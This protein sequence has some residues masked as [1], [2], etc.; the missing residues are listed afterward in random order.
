MAKHTITTTRKTAIEKSK[1]EIELIG[2]TLLI[3]IRKQRD[4]S[5]IRTININSEYE[6]LQTTQKNRKYPNKMTSKCKN[7]DR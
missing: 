4:N 3:E 7:R 2:L 5:T 6:I 1:T